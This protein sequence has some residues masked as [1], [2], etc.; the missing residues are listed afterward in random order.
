MYLVRPKIARKVPKPD[1]IYSVLIC[2]S[3][4]G[5]ASPFWSV[6]MNDL[7]KM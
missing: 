4:T 1:M 5:L 7:G 6:V 2:I 3:I